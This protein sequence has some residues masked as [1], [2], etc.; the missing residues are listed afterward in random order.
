M[1][2]AFESG[3]H[4]GSR[5][6]FD[7]AR[8]WCFNIDSAFDIDF[9]Q[10]SLELSVFQNLERR[11]RRSPFHTTTRVCAETMTSNVQSLPC[12]IAYDGDAD[13]AARLLV[14][15]Q[16]AAPASR[17]RAARAGAANPALS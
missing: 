10:P 13:V 17:A 7:V 16:G 5:L 4:E 14:K 9:V 2:S 11:R 15:G 6:L 12:N 8:P 3:A 1:V